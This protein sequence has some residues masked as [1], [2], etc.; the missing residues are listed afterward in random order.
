[1]QEYIII[2]RQTEHTIRATSDK[3][4]EVSAAD[5]GSSS[6]S[7]SE[8]DE[9]LINLINTQNQNEARSKAMFP[10]EVCR[11]CFC[12]YVFL[13][14]GSVQYT[15]IYRQIIAYRQHRQEKHSGKLTLV[16]LNVQ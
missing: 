8:N 5:D 3:L 6:D 4:F 15:F 14:A 2:R 16:G 1:M 10:V 12:H 13:F 11:L 9:A 7:D